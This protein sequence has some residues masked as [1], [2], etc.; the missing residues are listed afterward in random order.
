MRSSVKGELRH[1]RREEYDGG[2][3]GGD[4]AERRKW[5][6]VNLVDGYHVE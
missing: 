4:S 1:W 6:H 5:V 3:T 2:A